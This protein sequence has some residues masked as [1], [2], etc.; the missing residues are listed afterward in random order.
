MKQ[1]AVLFLALLI[2]AAPAKDFVNWTAFK[3]N[4]AYIAA[5][6]CVNKG[7]PEMHCKG[8]C[9]LRKKIAESHDKDATA[10]VPQPEEQKQLVYFVEE[11]AFV[12]AAPPVA[13]DKTGF[14][15]TI[16]TPQSCPADIFQPPRTLAAFFTA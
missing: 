9:Y 14:S 7:K 4:Q 15:E 12:T 11:M 13:L 6:L 5:T 8:K 1:I 16:F 3:I 10:P 2:L